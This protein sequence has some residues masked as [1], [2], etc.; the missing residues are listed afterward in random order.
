MVVGAGVAGMETAASMG[1]MGYRVLLVDKNA[2]VGGRAILLSK[3]FPTLDCASCIVTPKMASVS[4]HPNV[5]LMTYSEVDAIARNS[6]GSFAVELHK[7]ASFVDFDA[8]TGC[9]KCEE[10][11]TVAIP[12]EYNYGL[13]T[14]RAA[15]IAF[16]QA[17]PKKAV[18]Q[19]RGE[20]PCTFTCPANVKASGYVSLVRAGRYK[21]AFALHLE[22]APLV[23]SLARAC[24]A[25]CES[26]CTRGEKEGTVHIRAIKRF[27]VDR[28]YAEHPE[29]EYGPVENQLETRVAIVGSGPAGLSAAFYLARLGHQV[30]IFEA[31][32]EAG[33]MLRTAIPAYRLPKDV[34]DRDIKNVTALGVEIRT[35]H[36]VT[37]LPELKRQGFD[38]VLIT[39][40]AS[41]ENSLDIEGRDLD[42][43][44]GCMQFLHDVNV[45][46]LPDVKNKTVMVIGG[47]NSA[48]DPARAAI[49]MGAG[50]VIIN[51]R[52]G[53][54]EMPA[55]DWEIRGAEEEG[56]ELMLMSTPKRFIGKDGKLV[57]VECISM[58]LGAP[59]ESGRRRPVPIEGSEKTVPAD[60]AV[61]AIGLAPSTTDFPAE[62]KNGKGLLVANPQTLQTADPDVFACGDCVT[63]PTMIINAVAQ[64][65]RAAF[66]IDRRLKGEPLDV[67]F[68][69]VL[70]KTGKAAVLEEAKRFVERRPVPQ[71]ALPPDERRKTFEC[72]E[73]AMSEAEARQE[74]Q[75]C[76]NCAECSQ[77]MECVS[78]CAPKC[79]DF[80][81]KPTPLSLNVGAVV[82]STGFK[83]LDPATKELLGYGRFPDVISG[84][85]MDRLLAPT[86][87]YN[88][89]LRPSDGKEPERIAIILCVG[90]RDET[91][92]NPLC[93]RIG[94]MYAIK[95]AQLAMGALPMAEITIYM[96]DVR[97]FGKGYNEFY[98]QAKDM[99]IEFVKGK[100]ARIE[101][102]A[103]G[104]LA[105]HYEDMLGEGGRK[106][107][108]HDLVVLTVG[109]LPNT[110][111]FSLYKGGELAADDFGYVRE[112]DPIS[113]PA[114]TNVDGLFVAGTTIGVMDIPDTVLHSGAAATQAAAYLE[115]SGGRQ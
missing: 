59:D 81:Q 46:K 101:Q 8:C 50:R 76:M 2:S 92:C 58:V 97:A 80:A 115:R 77:C 68:D 7:K 25:P 87:P 48:M 47:G 10:I 37:S 110:D 93:C 61:L 19:R 74:A 49:R 91:V 109:F 6:D 22:N 106:I 34:V 26:D 32:R 72:Y 108:E 88:A 44:V 90:S 99:G 13:V 18:I 67:P 103:N 55:H 30:T 84:P 79:I 89:V 33:G 20:A 38:A 62:M 28:Y 96:I 27:M 69:G 100:V 11:C 42:G 70:D 41:D 17:V 56:V 4:H 94:C 21:E 82:V 71:P 60:V 102:L 35:G 14:R 65:R 78:V 64:G 104:N 112:V 29:P 16:P 111:V 114:R 9:G 85:Q 51:Y 95:Q 53:R 45:G 66:Y 86:R 3:V 5:Q 31:E 63:A 83:I 107:R 36:R 73:K 105:L 57:A 43:V 98:E 113:E 15:H 24:Y 75:R 23:G 54:Q 1:D 40:G 39:T 12:D 52:R